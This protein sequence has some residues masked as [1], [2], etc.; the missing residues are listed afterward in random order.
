MSRYALAV[1]VLLV[2]PL[3]RADD[4]AECGYLEIEAANTK[5]P[6]IDP[7]LKALERKLKSPPFTSWN[8]FRKLSGGGLALV[9][10]KPETLR[11]KLGAATILL[12]DRTDKKVDITATIDGADGKRVLDNKQSV[13]VGSWTAWVHNVKDGG[14]ILAL[15]CK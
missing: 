10:L 5:S 7:E 11:L 9:K 14:N 1:L 6:S 13:S 4:K 8:T 2:S 12:R 15:S 3:A